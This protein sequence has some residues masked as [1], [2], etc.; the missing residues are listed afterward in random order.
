MTATT[1]RK[2]STP[3]PKD[4]PIKLSD[5][6]RHSAAEF[7]H[8]KPSTLLVLLATYRAF[9]VLDRDQTEELTSSGL[10]N[11][12]FNAL[13]VLHRAMKPLTMS[14]L[15]DMMAVQPTNLSGIVKALRMK[16]FVQ[17]QL[18]GEDSRSRMVSITEAGEMF[19]KEFLPNHWRHIEAIMADLSEAER[20]EL[21]RLLERLVISIKKADG[22]GAEAGSLAL[23]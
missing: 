5:Q 2:K 21:V 13:V 15:G 3:P 17:Q 20:T 1:R 18:N 10:G 12:Q 11:I 16:G 7:K 14:Q 8:L 22:T 4:I 19:L 23:M 9:G 6:A